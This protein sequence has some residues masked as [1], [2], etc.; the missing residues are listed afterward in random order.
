MAKGVSSKDLEEVQNS[1]L[2]KLENGVNELNSL[3]NYY[4]IPI[5]HLVSI[6]LAAMLLSLTRT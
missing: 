4:T 3:S 6:Q 1:S 5:R 2:K